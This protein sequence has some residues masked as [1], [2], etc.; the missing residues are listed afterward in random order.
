VTDGSPAGPRAG[1]EPEP[2]LAAAVR[3]RWVLFLFL[4]PFVGTLYPDWYSRIQ[5]AF[6]G[7]PFFIWY[8]FAMVIVG[9]LVT[10]TVYLVE[11]GTR[12]WRS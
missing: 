12:D 1:S 10:I 11:W 3:R 7:I 6:E 2:S 4:V 8:Q 5:P 9:V